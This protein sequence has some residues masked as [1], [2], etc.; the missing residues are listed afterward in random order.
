MLHAR[1]RQRHTPMLLG[2]LLALLVGAPGGA[3]PAGA[4][5]ASIA[6]DPNVLQI[7]VPLGQS[8]TRTATITNL[9]SSALSPAVF[10]AYPAPAPAALSR[11]QAAQ[12][13][14]AVALPRQ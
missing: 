13:P 8:S 6:V 7:S 2:A 11:V 12:A 3:R 1:S 5:N 14:Q 4:A 10:E 9:S